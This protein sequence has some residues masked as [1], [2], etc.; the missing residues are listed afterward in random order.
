MDVETFTSYLQKEAQLRLLIL[1]PS[2]SDA[3][4]D[5]SRWRLK[6]YKN[7]L[8]IVI[9]YPKRGKPIRPK[10]MGK[11]IRPKAMELC[12]CKHR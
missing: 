11:P 9:N 4:K 7:W 5:E 12:L 6:I 1:G 2:W 10:A 3:V 8:A